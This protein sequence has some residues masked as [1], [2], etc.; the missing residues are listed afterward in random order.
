MA[1]V[2]R[3]QFLDSVGTL[4][5]AGHLAAVAPSSLLAQPRSAPFRGA[6]RALGPLQ[7]S[8]LGL[9]CMGM[10]GVYGQPKDRQEMI[11]LIRAAAE[12]GVTL[13]DSAEAYGPYT[14]ETLVGEALAPFRR[15]VT[16]I[17]KFGFKLDPN[18]GSEILGVDSSP[19]HIRAVAEASL[20]RLRVEAIDL[21]F[22][23]RLDPAVPIE[24]VAGTIRDLVREGKVKHYGLCEVGADVIRRAHAVH[25]ISAI[26]SEYSL[27]TRKVETDVLPTCEALGIGFIP[28]SPLGRGF[29]T[30]RFSAETT[31]ESADMRRGMARFSPESLRANQGFVDLLG[32]VAAQKRATPPQ[33]ALA[34]LLS[35]KPF[36]VP[37]PGTTQLRHLD[38]NIG[39]AALDLSADDLREIETGAAAIAAKVG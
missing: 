27:W 1:P 6:R 28:Y 16:I 36:I 3:R 20:K 8:P 15:Q 23:H 38:D 17:T 10:T 19:A 18:G 26:Q 5:V 33:V 24:D 34:W 2:T 31:F 9:G 30:G 39:A 12:R 32:R 25:P 4:S 35:R 11:T 7:V 21:L 14:N 22:Q 37:I 13:F 29:L